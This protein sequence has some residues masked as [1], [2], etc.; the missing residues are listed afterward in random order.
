MGENL[1]LHINGKMVEDR[2][3]ERKKDRKKKEKESAE[4][5][6]G[7]KSHSNNANQMAISHFVI[8]RHD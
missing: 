1:K 4:A 8:S 6:S 7:L 3:I 5:I 2:E